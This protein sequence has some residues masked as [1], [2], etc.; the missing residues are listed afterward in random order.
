MEKQV[1]FCEIHQVGNERKLKKELD[2]VMFGNEKIN[3]NIQ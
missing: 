3:T 2:T 1:Q